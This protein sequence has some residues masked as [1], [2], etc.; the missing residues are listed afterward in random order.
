MKIREERMTCFDLP[1]L[2]TLTARKLGTVRFKLSKI[3]RV[4]VRV[5]RGSTA[6]ATINPGV[7]SRGTKSLVWTAPKKT[8][9]YGV[10]V[11]ATDL[12]GNTGSGAGAVEVQR[13]P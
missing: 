5:T 9:T 1:I 11:T 12:A 4:S 13:R 10:S 8:G 6:V 7:L 2:T 3:S